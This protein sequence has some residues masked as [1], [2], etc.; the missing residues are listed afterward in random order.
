MKIVGIVAEYNPFHNGH[1]YHIEQTKK[2]TG[3]DAVVV[4]M[5]GNFVQRGDCAIADKWSRAHVAL[6]GGA[7]LVIELPTYY[8]LGVAPL[9]AHGAVATLDALGCI[10]NISF[11][12]ETNTLDKLINLRDAIINNADILDKQIRDQ[13]DKHTGYPAVRY[14]VISSVCG[15]DATL[16]KEPNNML[17]LE[18]LLSLSRLKSNIKPIGITRM[19]AHYHDKNSDG[20]FASAASLR[21]LIASNKKIDA[22]V[23]ENICGAYGEL[24][25]KGLFPIF[26][27]SFD[28]MV[29]SY[30]RR[31][32]AST[33]SNVL[34]MPLGFEN[35]IIAMAN[36]ATSIDE[37]ARLCSV[38]QYTNARIRR[39]L[40]A[41]FI[42]IINMGY[43]KM[44]SYVRV[45]GANALG[46]Q[47]LAKANDTCSLPII[48]KTADYKEKNNDKLFLLDVTATDLYC[49]AYDDDSLR[50][51]GADFTTSPV[52]L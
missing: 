10:D 33:L 27:K 41:S 5:S 26:S 40:F 32:D 18:Y 51:G 39:L 48:T 11:G 1:K 6:L 14:D 7:D 21:E 4:I 28:K 30:L 45:L 16:L 49:A 15:T 3:A 37:L 42:G 13:S 2:K 46:K 50:K 35:R 44:P 23:P 20:V 25:K 29:I 52:M 22:S 17:A 43:E 36:K 24:N 34:D 9:F 31:S 12:M 19:G 47:V 8:A 38:R